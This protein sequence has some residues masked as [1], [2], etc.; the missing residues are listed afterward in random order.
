MKVVPDERLTWIDEY[1]VA[2]LPAVASDLG[3]IARCRAACVA[4]RHP[5]YVCV[6]CQKCAELV[7]AYDVKG[8]K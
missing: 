6:A 1:H 8:Q 5:D 4:P 2:H 7:A 3:A